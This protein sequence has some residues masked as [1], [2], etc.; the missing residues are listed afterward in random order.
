MQ[1]IV[2]DTTAIIVLSKIERLDL[3]FNVFEKIYIPRA[4]YEE[5]IKKDDKV[6]KNIK[7]NSKIE[8]KNI[9]NIE[10]YNKLRIQKLDY[11]ESE[12]IT[13][14]KELN[15]ALLIDEKDG[16][17]IALK[18]NLNIVGMLGIIRHNF[19]NNNLSYNEMLEIID[20]MKRVGFRL[21]LNFLNTFLQK[22]KIEK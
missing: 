4:V 20:N 12:A 6:S 10:L 18:E 2:S 5:I 15:L 21:N 9:S 8:I 13:L 1:I 19:R 3:I 16:R 11:G 22:L 7:S 14:A 17:K